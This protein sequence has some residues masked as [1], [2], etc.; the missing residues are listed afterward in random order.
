[1]V[2]HLPIQMTILGLPQVQTQ[3]PYVLLFSESLPYSSP[4]SYLIH[5][6]ENGIGFR[7]W[8]CGIGVEL[9][10]DTIHQFDLL[11]SDLFLVYSSCRTTP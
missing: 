7:K 4:V 11:S 6:P 3:C 1:L 2:L 8:D 9:P 5:F 10:V